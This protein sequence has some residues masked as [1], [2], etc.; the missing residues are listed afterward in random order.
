LQ[1][2]KASSAKIGRTRDHANRAH[3][4]CDRSSSIGTSLCSV[5]SCRVRSTNGANA[6]TLSRCFGVSSRA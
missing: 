3:V 1:P 4:A 5:T 6:C 2:L